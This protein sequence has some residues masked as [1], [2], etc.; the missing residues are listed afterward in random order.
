MAALLAAFGVAQPLF[1]ADE[2]PWYRYENDFFI[3]YSNASN[4]KARKILEDLEYFRGAALRVPGIELPVDTEKTLVLI[5]ATQEEF[6]VLAENENSV[7]F[8]Q[9][10]E[11]RTVIVFPASGR[12]MKSKYILHHEYAHALAHVAPGLYPQWYIEGFAEIASSAVVHKRRRSIFIGLNEG[13]YQDASEPKIDWDELINDAFDAHDFD[14]VELTASAYAQYWLLAHYL[15]MS[16]STDNISRLEQYFAQVE[17]GTPSADAFQASFG[18]TPTELWELELK[19]YLR[20]IPEYR[21]PFSR[22]VLDTSFDRE[23]AHPDEVE[24]LLTFFTHKAEMVRGSERPLRPLA[25]LPGV[26]DHLRMD[27]QCTETLTFR[28]SDGGDVLVM[29][30]FYSGSNG[31]SVPGVFRIGHNYGREFILHNVTGEQFPDV[32]L[33]PNYQLSVRSDRVLCFDEVPATELCARVL[34]RCGN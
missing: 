2:R 20:R 14:D 10:L 34:Q 33:T 28:L 15:T 1:A 18:V 26:W 9:P 19:P 23:P 31:K 22:D 7:G 17:N 11:G 24:S 25:S 13:R 29:E 21:H 3:A 4:W 32:T 5:P 16:G 12:T 8:A 30:D 6:A 27:D